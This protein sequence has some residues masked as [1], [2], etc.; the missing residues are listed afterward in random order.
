MIGSHIIPAFYLEQFATKQSK[1]KPGRTWVYEKGKE[2]AH[3]SISVQGKERGYFATLLADRLVDDQ[4]AERTLAALENECNE[5]LFCSQSELFDWSSWRHRKKLAFYAGLLYARTTQRRDHSRLVGLQIYDELV[6]AASD[7]P[8]MQGMADTI[9]TS[10]KLHAFTAE[11]MQATV[12]NLVRKGKDSAEMNAHFVSNLQWLAEYFESLLLQKYWQVWRPPEGMEFATS[13]NPVVNFIPL[14]NGPFHPGHGFNRPGVLT[15]FP[16]APHACLI[17]GMAQPHPESRRVDVETVV[18]TNDALISI[19]DRYVYTKTRSER[20]HESVKLY[21]GS[22]KYGINALLPIGMKM[23]KVRDF[24][25]Q[26]F[27]LESDG[28]QRA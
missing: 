15:A 8:L 5:I 23:P 7:M 21:A 25:L 20:I 3:R 6:S 19:C 2:P 27:G 9:N 28:S 22:F 12:L 10:F 26:L 1:K 14:P 13:D 16:L 17:M 11:S 4:E 18:K 24:L